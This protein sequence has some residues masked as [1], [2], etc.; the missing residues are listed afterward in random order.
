MFTVIYHADAA[1]EFHELPPIIRGK[2]AKLIGKL[3]EGFE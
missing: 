2:M 1:T 3:E